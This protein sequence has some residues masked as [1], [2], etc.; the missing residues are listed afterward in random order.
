[1]TIVTMSTLNTLIPPFLKPLLRFLYYPQERQK[2]LREPK[3]KKI[4][5]EK[6]KQFDASSGKLIL[7]LIEGADYS[8]GVDKISGGIIS[9]VSLCEESR[10]LQSIHGAEVLLCTFPKQHLL[11]KHIRF[12]NELDVFRFDQL[13]PYFKQ[14]SEIVIHLPE[15]LCGY[16]VTLMEEGKL[17]WLKKMRQLQI[18]VLNQNVRLMPSPLEVSRLKEYNSFVTVTTAHQQYCTP[19]FQKLLQVPLHKFSVWIS[20]EKYSFRPYKEKKNLIVVSPDD[21][22]EKNSILERLST[23]PGLEVLVIR[24]LTYEQYKEKISL[25]KWTLTFG[26]GLDGYFIEPIFSGAIGFAVYNEDFFTSDFGIL[27]TLYKSFD[28]MFEKIVEDIYELD[29][30]MNFAKYQKEQFSLCAKY[31]SRQEYLENIA[32]FYRNHYTYA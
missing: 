10:K 4:Q 7:F 29:D 11:A 21:C 22:P 18:N 6:I 27:P 5:N 31:Y 17:N 30:S 20:P 9:I 2:V 12:K 26:E 32:A 24:N 8:T 1:M 13:E 25:A 23:I 14:A 3:I 16:F 28:T 15:Y 19:E